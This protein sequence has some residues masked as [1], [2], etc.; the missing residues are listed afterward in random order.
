MT[1]KREELIQLLKFIMDDLIEG[2]NI[3][4]SIPGEVETDHWIIKIEEV[5][6]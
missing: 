2:T 1:T 4:N 3:N 6:K 5:H